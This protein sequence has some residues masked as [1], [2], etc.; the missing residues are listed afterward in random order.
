MK[1]Q[2]V[3]K[4]SVLQNCFSSVP[5]ADNFLQLNTNKTK[6]LTLVLLPQLA[7]SEGNRKFWFSFLFCEIYPP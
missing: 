5:K 1:P 6:V 3:A 4:L 2:N 7:L